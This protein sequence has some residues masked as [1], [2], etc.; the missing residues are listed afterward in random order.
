MNP[1]TVFFRLSFAY[2]HKTK[3]TDMHK[4]SCLCGAV[5]FEIEGDLAPVEA[6]H[7]S[8]CRKWTSHFLASTEVLRSAL[9]VSGLESLSWFHSSEKV[10]RGFCSVC[11]ASCSLIQQTVRSTTGSVYRWVRSIH[12]PGQRWLY[13][14]S[15][16]KKATTTRSTTVCRKIR[17][18]ALNYCTDGPDSETGMAKSFTIGRF[19]IDEWPQVP[20][21]K[22]DGV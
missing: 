7:C 15:S 4:G 14:S 19:S 22:S 17:L 21:E 3:G 10:R 5:T 9:T 1:L 16:R 6:C 18:D 8:Q 11:G 12:R 13:I 20:T 2:L